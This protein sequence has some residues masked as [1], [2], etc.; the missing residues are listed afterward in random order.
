[1]DGQ[2]L[3]LAEI[4]KKYGLSRERVR[5]I[6]ERALRKLARRSRD[7]GAPGHILKSLLVPFGSDEKA[8]VS[9][10]LEAAECGFEIPPRFAVKFILR[11]AGYTKAKEEE[12]SALLPVPIRPRKAKQSDA[13][14]IRIPI[15]VKPKIE[16]WLEHADWPDVVCPPPPD[17]QLSAHR[18]VNDSDIAGN[19]YSQKL[20]RVVHFESNL[21]FEIFTELENCEQIAYYQEQPAKIP[22]AF[23]GRQRKYFPDILAITTD[24]RGL[25]IEVK[26][27]D[28]MALSVNRAKAAAGRAWAHA[29]GWGWLVM[30]SRHTLREIEERVL[31]EEK[32][33]LLENELKM[34]GVLTWLDQL[35][36]RIEQA[37]TRLDFTTYIIQ[38]GAHLDRAYRMTANDISLR[39]HMVKDT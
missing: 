11:A 35:R 12:V 16:K 10:L 9:W 26:P 20:D 19:F 29:R 13:A 1:M 4:G 31:S 17:T 6:Q 30:N 23:K 37:L 22:Y 5:Q 3:T 8:L 28:N 39:G 7:Q 25:L 2:P 24:G 36:L 14:R 34:H 32:R 38:S 15:P 18:V 21:E 27:T 33:A